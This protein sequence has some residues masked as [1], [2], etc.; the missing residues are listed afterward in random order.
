MPAQNEPKEEAT[1]RSCLRAS[2]RCSM[3]AA[4]CGPIC[5]G[6]ITGKDGEMRKTGLT[7]QVACQVRCGAVPSRPYD[8]RG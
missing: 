7:E 3:Q 6:K 4:T 1:A 8:L 2:F 5:G